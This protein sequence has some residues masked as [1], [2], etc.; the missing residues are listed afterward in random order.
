M[1]THNTVAVL[2]PGV[3]NSA[4]ANASKEHHA[5]ISK[6]EIFS[7]QKDYTR[8]FKPSWHIF[9]QDD[10]NLLFVFADGTSQLVTD[11]DGLQAAMQKVTDLQGSPVYNN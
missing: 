7:L 11:T 6:T 2:F 4:I 10:V 9:H 8:Y 1:S 3:D 5:E